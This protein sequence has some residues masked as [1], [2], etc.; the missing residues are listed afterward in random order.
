VVLKTKI[1]YLRRM[2]AMETV[3]KW[4]KMESKHY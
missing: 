1:P 3:K 2:R 4:S